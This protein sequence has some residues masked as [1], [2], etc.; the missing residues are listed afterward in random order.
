MMTQ[1]NLIEAACLSKLRSFLLTGLIEDFY[2]FYKLFNLL[3]LG[4]RFRFEPRSAFM[5][6]SSSVQQTY[7]EQAHLIEPQALSRAYAS[8]HSCSGLSCP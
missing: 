7:M 1:P 2:S 3:P 6:F 5:T 4:G 8:W